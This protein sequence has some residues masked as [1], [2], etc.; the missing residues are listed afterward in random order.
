MH[1]LKDVD[2]LAYTEV[3]NINTLYFENP[4]TEELYLTIERT[5]LKE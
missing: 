2:Y 4:E 3:G 5:A 1:Y